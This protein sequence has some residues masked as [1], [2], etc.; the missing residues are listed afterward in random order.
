[1][2]RA[3]RGPKGEYTGDSGGDVATV[4]DE[5]MDMKVFWRVGGG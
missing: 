1:M 2:D 3:D 5:M 4:E